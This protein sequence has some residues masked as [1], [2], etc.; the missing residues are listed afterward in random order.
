[1]RCYSIMS[2][3]IFY[4]PCH[5]AGVLIIIFYSKIYNKQELSWRT[6]SARGLNS[7]GCDIQNN[8]ENTGTRFIDPVAACAAMTIQVVF[9]YQ[10]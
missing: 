7:L 1:M 6:Q 4:P 3:H 8:S 10:A 9:N 2:Y 5:V